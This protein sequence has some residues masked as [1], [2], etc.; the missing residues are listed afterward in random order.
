MSTLFVKFFNDYFLLEYLKKKYL[1]SS[2]KDAGRTYTQDYEC[3]NVSLCSEDLSESMDQIY[4]LNADIH[5]GSPSLSRLNHSTNT[6]PRP[7][8]SASINEETAV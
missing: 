1:F 6:R 2:I 4:L 8:L 7:G 3:T 5:H